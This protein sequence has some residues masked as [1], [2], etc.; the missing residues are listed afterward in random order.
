[1]VT[2][3]TVSFKWS[4]WKL[5]KAKIDERA[6]QDY[7]KAV[8]EASVN[9]FKRG[10]AGAGGGPVYENARVS[11]SEAGEYPVSQSGRL[12]GSLASKVRGKTLEVSV[13]T[14]YAQYLL[15]TRKMAHRRL[16]DEALDEGMRQTNEL[17]YSK[18]FGYFTYGGTRLS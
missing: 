18:K 12:L 6:L 17:Q 3:A 5:L 1:M 13:D 15:G 10:S 7:L 16:V 14:P 4:N 11:A 2:L 9:A 8:G